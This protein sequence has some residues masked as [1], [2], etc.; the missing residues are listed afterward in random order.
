[1]HHREIHE[2]LLR[3]GVSLRY[4]PDPVRRVAQALRA[5][6]VYDRKQAD[7][8]ERWADLLENEE[9]ST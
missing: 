6:A 4:Q 3:A 1:M 2:Q 5:S 9:E 8:K 7:A